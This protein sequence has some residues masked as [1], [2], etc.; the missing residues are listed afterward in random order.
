MIGTCKWCKHN[1]CQQH[2]LP[3]EH[4]CPGLAACRKASYDV[5]AEKNGVPA[6]N[7]SQLADC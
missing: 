3:E 5:N 7:A 4:A 6:C 2:R 1:F